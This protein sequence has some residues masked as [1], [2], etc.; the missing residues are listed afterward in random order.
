M[1]EPVTVD[2]P[3]RPGDSGGASWEAPVGRDLPLPVTDENVERA[4]N[5]SRDRIGKLR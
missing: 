4:T 5:I 2:M 3:V 1:G